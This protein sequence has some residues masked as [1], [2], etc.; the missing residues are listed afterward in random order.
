MLIENTNEGQEQDKKEQG[1]RGRKTRENAAWSESGHAEDQQQ[2]QSLE[3]S[4]L[5][6]DGEWTPMPI[7]IH[8]GIPVERV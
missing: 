6:R 5:Q 1:Q 2:R 8:L 3:G 4:D 7:S